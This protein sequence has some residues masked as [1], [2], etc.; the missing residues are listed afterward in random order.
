[1]S[2]TTTSEGDRDTSNANSAPPTIRNRPVGPNGTPLGHCLS[3]DEV[4]RDL[5]NPVT[6]VPIL[7]SPTVGI[8]KR[9]FMAR[10]SF[11]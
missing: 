11:G 8:P 3:K 5:I 7:I 6:P 4:S 9:D 10:K 1:M 2:L